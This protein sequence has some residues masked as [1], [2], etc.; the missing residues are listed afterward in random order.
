MDAYEF[1]DFEDVRFFEVCGSDLVERY[2]QFPKTI[3]DNWS[4]KNNAINIIK[5]LGD[6][7]SLRDND[8]VGEYLFQKQ[9]LMP[10]LIELSYLIKNYFSDEELILD[11]FHDPMD[12]DDELVIYIQTDLEVKD[13]LHNLKLLNKERRKKELYSSEIMVDVEFT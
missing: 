9:H 8:S 5:R 11:V 13:A 4:T 12:N 10:I 7:F 2:P 1:Q 3:L 6:F